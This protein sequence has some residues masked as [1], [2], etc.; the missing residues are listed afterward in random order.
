MR[1][2]KNMSGDQPK[3]TPEELAKATS[4]AFDKFLRDLISTIRD[5]HAGHVLVTASGISELLMDA[6]LTKM[7]PLT[8]REREDLFENFGPLSSFAGRIALAFA[9]DLIGPEMRNDL[10]TVKEIRNKFA[11]PKGH[12][13][14]S[15]PV[16]VT[17][18]KRL[19][20]YD[21]AQTDLLKTAYVGA[22]KK[23]VDH[24]RPVVEA[25]PPADD[26]EQ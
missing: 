4:D 5:T 19:S 17:L 16:I 20:S 13:H 11:H 8:K 21:P 26:D 7:R 10:L 22:L 1:A 6:L 9:L 2:R 15:D 12:H 14:F 24:L 3:R 23:V 18:C 25:A